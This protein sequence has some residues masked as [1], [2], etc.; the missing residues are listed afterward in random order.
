MGFL[1]TLLC[2]FINRSVQITICVSTY[3]CGLRDESTR[4]GFIDIPK[5]RDIQRKEKGMGFRRTGFE[6][7]VRSFGVVGMI[8]DRFGS[9]ATDVKNGVAQWEITIGASCFRYRLGLRHRS[10]PVMV[11]LQHASGCCQLFST[12]LLRDHQPAGTMNA[13][14]YGSKP[15]QGNLRR[16]TVN[17]RDPDR[18]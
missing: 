4:L 5:S 17:C 6:Y 12:T 3:H 7:V 8:G 9:M 15:C 13:H 14:P 2:C 1:T 11:C 16:K 10:R 18:R